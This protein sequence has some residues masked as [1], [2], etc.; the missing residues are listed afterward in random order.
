MTGG[1]RLHWYD[2][3]DDQPTYQMRAEPETYEHEQPVPLWRRLADPARLVEGL[4]WDARRRTAGVLLLTTAELSVIAKH[5]GEAWWALLLNM[6]LRAPLHA[7]VAAALLVL[8]GRLTHR[9]ARLCGGDGDSDTTTEVLVAFAAVMAFPAGVALLL[10]GDNQDIVLTLELILS[11]VSLVLGIR[12]VGRLE[13]LDS[14]RAAVSL[15]VP[16]L[17]VMVLVALLTVAQ[18]YLLRLVHLT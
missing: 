3:P 4:G 11:V 15:V 14:T 18:A 9:V 8:L 2:N 12:A 1:N 7:A 10:W 13:G 5:D 16:G 6:L 17:L